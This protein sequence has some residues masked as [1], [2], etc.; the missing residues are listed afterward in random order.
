MI[1]VMSLIRN[2]R[3]GGHDRIL[4]IPLIRPPDRLGTS[5][6]HT[7]IVAGSSLSTHN[8]V[9]AV[10]LGQMWCLDTATVCASAPD[11]LRIAD[12]LFFHRI[13][14][15]QCDHTRLLISLSGLPV[16]GY[17]IFSSVIIVQNGRIKTGGMQ[18]DRFTPWPPDIL[19]RDQ[20]IV[21]IKISCIHGIHDTIDHIEQILLL[22]IRQA[23]CPDSLGRR[24]FLQIRIGIIRQ[25]M[26]V[27]FPV[28]HIPGMVYRNPRKPFKCG[29]RN[30]IIVP[31]ATDTRVRIK[32]LQNRIFKHSDPLLPLQDSRQCHRIPC[33]DDRTS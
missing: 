32:P 3:I 20:E 21:H 26:C 27:Q 33:P 12:D 19:C 31:F 29:H 22:T 6:R 9:V 5:H 8:I 30:I 2:D 11:A 23:W 14:L 15:G 18:I 10:P 24:K 16:Q 4:R 13:I 25:Y 17:D 28:F 7:V 1:R